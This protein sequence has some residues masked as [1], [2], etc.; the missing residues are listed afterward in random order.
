MNVNYY[1]ITLKKLQGVFAHCKR[2]IGEKSKKRKSENT[3]KLC[4]QHKSQPWY[5]A[6]KEM[7]LEIDN[8]AAVCIW[9]LSTDI[10]LCCSL[11]LK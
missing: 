6:Y 2:R 3:D 10:Y 4:L 9:I 5:K 11:I 8:A 7:C 1:L